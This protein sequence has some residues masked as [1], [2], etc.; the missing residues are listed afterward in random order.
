M[1]NLIA[2]ALVFLLLHRLVSGTRLRDTIVA[3]VGDGAFM[4]LFSLASVA[5]LIWLGVA[6]GA[7]RGGPGDT[8][9]WA[10][11]FTTR[12]LQLFIQFV[13]VLF[14]VPGLMTR[15]PT[16]V[17]QGRAGEDQDVVQGMLRIT[18]HPFLWGVAIWA[19]GHLLVD[20]DLAS[21]T[22]FGAFLVLALTG[23]LS[24]DAKRRRVFGT[25]WQEFAHKTSNVPFAAIAGGR[26]SLSI[27]EIGILRLG[28]AVVVYLFLLGA[29]HHVFGA[30]VLQPGAGL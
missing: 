11:T 27:G 3:V 13:A 17:G 9:Y 23:T 30:F 8:S 10:S 6:F 14:I 22:F 7:A 15:N 29:H 18:R 16:S 21:L 4:G 24:I 20:G 12:I 5:S 2:A 26:Q 25:M 19:A 1:T 28:A